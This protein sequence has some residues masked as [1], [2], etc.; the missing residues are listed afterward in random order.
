V[1]SDGKYVRDIFYVEVGAE[2]YTCLAEKLADDRTLAGQAFNFSNERPIAVVD[3]VRQI[4]KIMDSDLEPDI[5]DEATNDIRCQYLDSK[6]ARSPLEWSPRFD[7]DGG[8]NRT[9]A[10]Y[11]SFL[12]SPS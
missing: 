9:I 3:F 6:T 4:L 12:G 1:S 10:W 7:L 8:L 5:R 2:T 11:K